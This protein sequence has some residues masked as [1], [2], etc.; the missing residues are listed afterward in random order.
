MCARRNAP[1]GGRLVTITEFAPAKV[2]LGLAVTGRLENG[3]HSLDTLF[4]TTDVGDTLT[5]EATDS[6]IQLEVI[7]LQ[8]GDPRDNLV[9]KA[10]QSYLEFAG[11]SGGVR[12]RLEKRLPIAAGLGGGS[13]D[14]AAALRGLARLYPVGATGRSPLHAMAQALGADVPFLLKGGA[15]R[16]GG[17]GDL[18]EPI[19]LPQTH[20]VLANPNVG[21]TAKEAYA[22]LRGRY[23]APLDLEGIL[24][25]LIEKRAPP[26]RNDLE[27][28]VL[29]VY[30]IVQSVKDTLEAAGLY[31][32]LMS[33]SGST[34]FGLA[35]DA[36]HAAS[37]AAQIARAQPTWWV[38]ETVTTA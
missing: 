22:G 36:T 14:A 28:P 37:A 35:R 24:Q 12:M 20:L 30:P 11:V 21:I 16:G 4:T 31:G 3:Y 1:T 13:S 10:A 27:L 26:Y 34:C 32:V 5:L 2:N 18:L 6:G 7:G 23:G 25:A 29:E 38:A 19:A 15:A 33:G 8:L 9:Y 17:V